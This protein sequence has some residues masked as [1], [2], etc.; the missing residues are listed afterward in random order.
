MKKFFDKRKKKKREQEEEELRGIRNKTEVWQFINKKR[1]KREWKENN[2]GKEEWRRHFK[3]LLEEEEEEVEEGKKENREKV[4]IVESQ[5]Q[6][7]GTEE[8]EEEEQEITENEISMALR[9]MKMKKAAGIDGIP[10]E[11]WKFGGEAEAQE[12]AS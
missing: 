10:M 4:G 12:K 8:A 7:E 2:I 9:K 1:K 11:A 3:N 6:I 5:N